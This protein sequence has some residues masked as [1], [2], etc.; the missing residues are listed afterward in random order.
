MYFIF[1]FSINVCLLQERVSTKLPPGVHVVLCIDFLNPNFFFFKSQFSIDK[2]HTGGR[3][4]ASELLKA[5]M[6]RNDI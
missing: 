4:V 1:Y 5:Y 2:K 6:S 3:G